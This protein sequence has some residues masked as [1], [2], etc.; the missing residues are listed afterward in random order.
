MIK[1][2]SID[3]IIK[4]KTTDYLN[5]DSYTVVPNYII[6]AINDTLILGMYIFFASSHEEIEF[7]SESLH[8]RFGINITKLRRTVKELQ[9]LGFLDIL[10]IKH[11]GRFCKRI[12]KFQP[13]SSIFNSFQSLRDEIEKIFIQRKEKGSLR[14]EFSTKRENIKNNLI[15]LYGNQCMQCGKTNNLQVDH[16]YPLCKGGTNHESN[17]QLLC[18]TCNLRKGIKGI[19]ILN[20]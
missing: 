3:K 20:L 15:S 11:K 16:I 4:N 7:N 10:L 12:Y 13:E 2:N 8:K 5:S 9:H 6:Q 18:K 14:S 17:L 19:S 1:K